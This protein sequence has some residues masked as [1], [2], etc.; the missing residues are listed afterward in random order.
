MYVHVCTYQV[1][2][3]HQIACIHTYV[4]KCSA[5]VCGVNPFCM[6]LLSCL[7]QLT[8]VSK[9]DLGHDALSQHFGTVVDDSVPSRIITTTCHT[10]GILTGLPIHVRIRILFFVLQLHDIMSA[11]GGGSVSISWLIDHM[12]VP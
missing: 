3:K 5:Y 10:P 1:V 12:Y 11:Y 7:A 8:A 6:T 9:E 4:H 2:C